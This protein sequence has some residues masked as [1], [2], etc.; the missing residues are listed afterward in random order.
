MNFQFSL[1]SEGEGE[2]VASDLIWT[3]V[4]KELPTSNTWEGV[5]DTFKPVGHV[6]K[7]T[8]STIP[9]YQCQKC[10]MLALSH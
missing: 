1:V 4:K 7:Y 8:V 10:V 6:G 3:F 2:T 5:Y 9:K